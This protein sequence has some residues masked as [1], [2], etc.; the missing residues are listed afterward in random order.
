VREEF[1]ERKNAR[2]PAARFSSGARS[3]KNLPRSLPLFRRIYFDFGKPAPGTHFAD[4]LPT[5]IKVARG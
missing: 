2:A 4:V 1:G 5:L 3:T